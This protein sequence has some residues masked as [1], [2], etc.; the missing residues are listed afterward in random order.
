MI[1][2]T[3]MARIY[4]KK[5]VHFLR[6]ESTQRKILNLQRRFKHKQKGVRDLHQSASLTVD[7]GADLHQS[8]AIDN[9]ILHLN[10]RSTWMHKLLAIEFAQWLDDDFWIWCVEVIDETLWGGSKGQ[11]EYI[12]YKRKLLNELAQW[13]AKV[14]EL[15]KKLR[16]L[17]ILKEL[18]EAKKNVKSLK[19]RLASL[20]SRFNKQLLLDFNPT[21]STE[22]LEYTKYEE[23]RD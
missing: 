3:D 23:V 7:F 13:E 17:E 1:S 14:E 16:E 18:E 21:A 12:Q 10:K 22:R 11:I 20:E 5:A 15:E 9:R 6:L 4:R 8:P 2:A 19:A